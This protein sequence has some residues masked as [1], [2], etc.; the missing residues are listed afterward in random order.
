M[1]SNALY[2]S[3]CHLDFEPL[4]DPSVAG[5]AA[6]AGVRRLLV[7]GVDETQWRRAERLMNGPALSGLS[8]R[9]AVGVHPL[10]KPRSRDLD[11]MARATER[12]GAVAIGELGWDRAAV[13]HAAD[14]DAFVDDCLDLASERGLPVILHIVG[15]H[16]HALSRLSR[17]A[18]VQGVVHAYSGSLEL[19]QEYLTL[20]LHLSVGPAVLRPDAKK[21]HAS[22]AAIPLERLLIETDAP[23]QIAEPADLRRV[24][25]AVASVRDVSEESIA[26]AT[27]ENAERLFGG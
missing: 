18:P 3:H 4:A 8:L 13:G 2:D 7:P 16:G 15:R 21:V 19:V 23:D 12:L 6:E 1:Q 11:D 26:R 9:F 5:R 14:T 10:A 24:S 20:G 17:R 22:A 27:W 25:R